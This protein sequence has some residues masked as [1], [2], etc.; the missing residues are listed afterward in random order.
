MEKPGSATPSAA[1]LLSQRT[2]ERRR[3]G[4]IGTVQHELRHRPG[5]FLLRGFVLSLP[6]VYLSAY[7]LLLERKVYWPIGV[8]A[9]TRQN[10]FGIQPQ[11]RLS[12]R[13][14]EQFLQP[15]HWLDRRLRREYWETIEHG[16]GRRWK[17]PPTADRSDG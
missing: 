5:R 3:R 1:V 2:P 12:A 9:A 4:L 8:D 11:Y 13:W 6:L 10:L 15:A 7:S 17:N 14:V 16:S